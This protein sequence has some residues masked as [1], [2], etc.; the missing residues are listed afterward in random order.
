[1]AC[2]PQ[3]TIDVGA[4]VA[5]LSAPQIATELGL[6]CVAVIHQP[7]FSIFTSFDDVLLL[8]RGGRTV[9]LGES[10]G[11]LPYFE[12]CPVVRCVPQSLEVLTLWLMCLADGAVPRVSLPSK[13]EPRGL[14]PGHH[15][16]RPRQCAACQVG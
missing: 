5:C 7:R 1:M 3:L 2:V 10:K 16:Q 13:G 14:F 15:Q 4:L 12:V 11:A 9:Y 8:G 6:T